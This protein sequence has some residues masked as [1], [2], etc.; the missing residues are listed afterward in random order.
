MNLAGVVG[1]R[2]NQVP[3]VAKGIPKHHDFAV[4]F[5]ARFFQKL[6]PGLF[7]PG[8]VTVKTIGFQNEEDAAAR[9]VADSLPLIL[10]ISLGE[11]KSGFA[12]SRWGDN[13]PTLGIGEW[14]ILDK[15]EPKPADIVGDGSIVVWNQQSDYG[16]ML[17]HGFHKYHVLLVLAGKIWVILHAIVVIS[18]W[19]P[20]HVSRRSAG[21]FSVKIRSFAAITASL[22]QDGGKYSPCCL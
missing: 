15:T 5:K 1:K 20:V 2:F 16:D 17:L 6:N 12:A 11:E 21:S 18:I 8:I 13:D 9:L 10:R 4:G 14:C 3:F 22:R 7:E 19:K